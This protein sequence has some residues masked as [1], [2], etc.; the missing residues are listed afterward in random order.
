ML[1]TEPQGREDAE[2][3]A[4]TTDPGGHS[5]RAS[6]PAPAPKQWFDASR[7]ALV[8]LPL[9]I[10]ACAAPTPEAVRPLATLSGIVTF[11][12]SIAL[13]PDT[14]LTVHLAEVSRHDAPAR[15]LAEQII[16]NPGA[17]P[18]PFELAYD[19]DAIVPS[20]SYA[21]HAR[22]EWEGR[23][24]FVNERRYCAI[25]RGCPARLEVAVVPVL[26]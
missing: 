22:I 10:A 2:Q 9:A 21:V 24:L 20:R 7:L 12:E 6:D 15:V 18:I 23:V 14:V 11:Q 13:S 1:G 3:R 16:S 19:P 17:S 26:R 8:L 25:T 5:R 4:G